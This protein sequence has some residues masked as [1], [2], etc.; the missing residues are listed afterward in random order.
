LDI[1]ASVSSRRNNPS[2]STSLHSVITC[3]MIWS[4]SQIVTISVSLPA[5]RR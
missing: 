3:R 4:L 1:A 2:S 5:D